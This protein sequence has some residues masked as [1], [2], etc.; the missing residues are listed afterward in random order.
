[1]RVP[2]VGKQHWNGGMLHDVTGHST[3]QELPIIAPCA[4]LTEVTA[5]AHGGLDGR[6]INRVSQKMVE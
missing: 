3:E 6:S 5:R 4:P 2:L 1:M